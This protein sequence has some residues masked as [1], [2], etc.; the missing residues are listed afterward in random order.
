MDDEQAPEDQPLSQE[1]L[2]KVSGGGAGTPE[3]DAKP[4]PSSGLKEKWWL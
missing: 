4:N 2:D 3:V 1:E